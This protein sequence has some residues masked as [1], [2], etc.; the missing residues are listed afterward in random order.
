MTIV[1]EKVDPFKGDLYRYLNFNEIEG[2]EN[3]GRV[4]PES[5]MPKLESDRTLKLPHKERSHPNLPYKAIASRRY[6]NQR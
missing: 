5:E 6:N 3:F 4:V 2:F 1:A